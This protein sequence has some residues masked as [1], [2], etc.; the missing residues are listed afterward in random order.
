VWSAL[1]EWFEFRFHCG[2]LY[3]NFIAKWPKTKERA[4]PI[5]L[6]QNLGYANKAM[7]LLFEHE[8][9]N[10]RQLGGVSKSKSSSRNH[11]N[12]LGNPS[13]GKFEQ[14]TG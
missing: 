6:Y 14:S 12:F 8:S 3:L 10:F 1:L 13:R 11:S 5:S 7:R 4:W 2:L 9:M